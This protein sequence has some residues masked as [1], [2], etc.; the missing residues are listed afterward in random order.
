VVIHRDLKPS[1]ILV[2]GRNHTAWIWDREQVESLDVPARQTMTGLRLMT[3][4]YAAPEQIRGQ[5]LGVQTDVY[6]LGVI[7]YQLLCDSLPF[8]L[9][10]LA[11]AEAETVLLEHEPPKPSATARRQLARSVA[12]SLSRGLWADL[13][14]LCLTAMRRDPERRYRSVEALIR[15]VDHYL[16]HEPLKHGRIRSTTGSGS[17]YGVI[18]AKCLPPPRQRYY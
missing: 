9:S 1:S 4:A 5:R 15:D 14:V 18:S 13:D 8:D 3:P 16:K 10:N 6:S 2:V 11:P 7:L 17:L 12:T